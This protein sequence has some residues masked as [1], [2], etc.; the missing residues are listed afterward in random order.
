MDRLKI[1][2][3]FVVDMVNT[4]DGATLVSTIVT[5]AHAMKLKVAAEGVETELQL[6][7]LRAI[8]CDEMQGF[9]YSRPL[10]AETLEAK[11]LASP[12]VVTAKRR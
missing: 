2:R 5:L 3:S 7:M 4:T 11:F 8:G 9:L 6:D 1:D 10:P 12:G